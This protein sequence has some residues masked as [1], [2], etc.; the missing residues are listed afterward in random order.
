[1][2]S[3]RRLQFFFFL[4]RRKADRPELKRVS[5]LIFCLIY[6]QTTTTNISFY[7]SS[8]YINSISARNVI[9]KFF[10]GKSTFFFSFPK[11]LFPSLRRANTCTDGAIADVSLPLHLGVGRQVRVRRELLWHV[12]ARICIRVAGAGLVQSG[13]DVAL[14]E[15]QENHVHGGWIAAVGGERGVGL[16]VVGLGVVRDA[17]VR[18]VVA[19]GA[20]VIGGGVTRCQGGGLA[21]D[22][23]WCGLG[24][25]VTGV[26]GVL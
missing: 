14:D 6:V 24:L 25:E 3:K 26:H 19:V 20:K 4:K 9:I 15:I 10:L 22:D 8:R 13:D 7:I 12:V 21:T 18:G 23:A 16:Q 2:K 11:H 5:Q 17:A 1:M